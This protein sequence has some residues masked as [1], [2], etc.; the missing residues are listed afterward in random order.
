MRRVGPSCAITERVFKWWDYPIF[1][2]LSILS[3]YAIFALLS[4]WFS[5][6]DVLHRPISFSLMTV[7][8]LVVL[9]N[10][11]GR[12]FLLPFMRK[13]R[14][15]SPRSGWKVA[16][17]TTFVP[18]GEALEMLED[19]VKALVALD[20]PHD[21]WVLDEGNS[22]EVKS[23][24]LRLGARHFSRKDFPQYQSPAGVFQ[25]GAKHGN[26]NAWL[27]EVGYAAYDVITTFDPDHVPRR[28]YLARVLGYLEDPKVAYIQAAQVYCNQEASFIARGAAEE[29][30]A[31]Y[32]S[33][34]M[35]G[36]GMGYPIIVGCH[37]TH[38]VAALKEVGGFAAHDAEDLL[39][40]LTYRANG[41]QG[42][43]VPEIL[44]Q[45]LTPVDWQGY[46]QQQRRWARSVLDIK[47]RRYSRLSKNL[48]LQSHVMSFLHGL[49]YLHRTVIIFLTILL[50]GFMLATGRVPAVVSYGTAQKLGI[51]CAVL[52]LCEFYRQRFY[53]DPRR[54]WGFHWRVAL[55]H[56]A[57]W[58]WFL[59]AFF[60]VLFKKQKP[61]VL[62]P[63][64]K[65]SAR[66]HALVAPNLLVILL[67]GLAWAVGWNADYA[68]HP[69]VRISAAILMSASATLIWTDF[70]DY[71]SPY[72]KELQQRRPASPDRAVTKDHA[73]LA[74]ELPAEH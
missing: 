6:A 2:L 15:V 61:Y 22:G 21:T 34:Q 73:N 68:I 42:V 30:Y 35:A 18:G 67:L 64:V 41:W 1:V 14:P 71:P 51:L 32:S 53:L 52:Q 39:L 26:Y 40:T 7:I 36:Y 33:V 17:A 63:K 56:Y 12:W 8:L 5:A 49:N 50:N 57:K 24:C 37:N 11:Q 3:V 25:S 72:Q 13:P 4:H 66:S 62:T 38:R 70:W 28:G 69:L 55:L 9:T 31:Y 20:H 58:P 60:D 74:H 48:A 59:L 47:L 45:G 16:V 23:L 44:A 27:H 29:T 19:T 43:Y 10:N 65:S 54:E 46:L